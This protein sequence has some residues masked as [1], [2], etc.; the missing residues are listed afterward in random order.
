MAAQCGSHDVEAD[1]PPEERKGGGPRVSYGQTVVIGPWGEVLAQAPTYNER[2]ETDSDG[3]YYEI[4]TADVDL[5]H[6]E[7]IRRDLPVFGYEV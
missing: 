2:G 7:R 1:L 3:D 5:D 4:V 6:V